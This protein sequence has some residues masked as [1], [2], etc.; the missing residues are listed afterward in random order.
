MNKLTTGN[1]AFDS[2]GPK[3][4]RHIA[5]LGNALPRRC[6]LATFT[7]DTAS[8]VRAAFP[9]MKLDHYAMD[10]ASGVEYPRDIRTIAM[11]NRAAYAKAGRDIAISGADMLW[12]QHE[13]GIFGG[14]AGDWLL[15]LLDALSIPVVTTLHTL[16]ETPS[17]DER[18]VLDALIAR[19]SRLIVMADK[20]RKILTGTFGVD[21]AM[22]EV[23]PHGVPDR[24]LVDPDEMKPRFDLVG[25]KVIL[26]FGLLAPDKGIETMV[27][28]MPAIVAEQPQAVYVVLG[29]T[30]PN[31][32]RREGEAYRERLTAQAVKLGVADHVRFVDAFVDMPDLLDWLQAADVY[33][34]PYL[35]EGQITSGTLSYAVGLGKPVVATPYVHA[36][37]ILAGDHGVLVDFADSSALAREVSRLLG[38]ETA[39]EALARRAYGLGRTM[40]WERTAHRAVGL[41]DEVASSKRIRLVPEQDAA[42]LEPDAAAVIRMSDATGMLQHGLYSIP[43]RNHGYCLDDNARALILMCRM[44][45]LDGAVRSQWTN[46]YA[47]FVQH[48]WDTDTKVFRN[49]MSFD[50][51]WLEA[52]G[53]ED[54]T[55]R[56]VWSLGVAGLEAAEARHR[57]WAAWLYDQS[58]PT[59]ERSGSPRAMA[60]AMLGA[61]AMA[62]AK[63]GHDIS[64]AIIARFG[65]EL[66]RLLEAARRPDWSWFEAMLAYDNA[67]L[68]EALIRGGTVCGNQGYIDC[69]L[70]TLD[71]ILQQ[72]HAPEGHFRAV[73][74]DSFGRHYQAPHRFDQQPLEAQAVID[75]CSAAYDATGNQHWADAAHRAYRWFLGE[76]DLGLMVASPADRSCHDGLMPTGVNRNQG[77]ES[78]LA[79]QL[80]SCAVASLPK[81][82]HAPAEASVA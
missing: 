38:D 58:A 72:Q 57:E 18:R 20:G 44:P 9:E 76:N 37:E 77:A 80:S 54:S 70:E 4:I 45:G 69:G 24:A 67:R 27:A 29:A 2:N 52:E 39:R 30:H 43:D 36:R 17:A 33:V 56:A 12:V 16:L 23:V 81:R 10:D 49:F 34:T 41:F 15:D 79:L 68:P 78:I 3:R 21:P 73:G 71:W 35:K 8:A 64:A 60:F 46:V 82:S 14:E 55:G 13:Y 62:E 42:Y 5:L 40:L 66:V 53:S 74:A 19:S 47:A 11:D 31:L 7:S 22:I 48:A 32:K 59:I 6:G 1:S 25:R 63:P 26:T 61:A 65:D 51:R 28:A 50:R 75:A